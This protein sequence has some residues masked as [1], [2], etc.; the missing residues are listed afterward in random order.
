MHDTRQLTYTDRGKKWLELLQFYV[1]HCQCCVGGGVAGVG[2]SAVAG[3]VSTL[4]H[5]ESEA[6]KHFSTRTGC[7]C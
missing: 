5:I 3:G 2:V 4:E 7:F 1:C 6:T